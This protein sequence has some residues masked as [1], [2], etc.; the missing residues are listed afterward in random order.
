MYFQRYDRFVDVNGPEIRKDG[1]KHDGACLLLQEMLRGAAGIES[2]TNAPKADL[3]RLQYTNAR[4]PTHE[5][6][7][8]HTRAVSD[9]TKGSFLEQGGKADQETDEKVKGHIIVGN[10]E[11]IFFFVVVA[12]STLQWAV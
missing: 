4:L 2:K 8:W 1:A 6:H 10:T 12:S 3:S 9:I 5:R 7:H 11:V